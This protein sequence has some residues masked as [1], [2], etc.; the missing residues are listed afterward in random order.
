MEDH[1]ALFPG[2]SVPI[3]E[4][5]SVKDWPFP[6]GPLPGIQLVEETLQ[7]KAGDFHLSIFACARA[8]A[9]IK[10]IGTNISEAKIYLQAEASESSVQDVLLNTEVFVTFKGVSI[11]MEGRFRC[12]D[13]CDAQTLETP[14]MFP[15]T[16]RG[17]PPGF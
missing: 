5:V 13:S 17:P 8:V 11:D 6:Y 15:S 9:C 4:E 2:S 3:P 16:P 12:H 1:R 10:L 14:L 7:H